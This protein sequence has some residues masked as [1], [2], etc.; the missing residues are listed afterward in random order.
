VLATAKILLRVFSCVPGGLLLLPLG[1]LLWKSFQ[2]SSELLI[3]V[4]KYLLWE[5]LRNTI[6]LLISVLLLSSIW[7]TLLAWIISRFQFVG[8]SFFRWALLLPLALPA[9]VVSFVWLANF[10]QSMPLMQLSLIL[11]FCLFPYIYLIVLESFERIDQNHLEV[12]SSL[13]VTRADVIRRIYRPMLL[14][15]LMAGISLVGM[16][17]L[18][19]FGSV[20][21][22]NFSV[23]TTL[24]YRSWFSLQSLETAAF[25]AMLH[26]LLLL[27]FVF[28][29]SLTSKGRLVDKNSGA[30]RRALLKKCSTFQSWGMG[31]IVMLIW[32]IAFL[33]PLFQ[34]VQWGVKDLGAFVDA[35]LLER[36]SN[37]LI[38][39]AAAALVT[40]I[41]AMI[42]TLAQ[43]YSKTSF[44][45]YVS[46][47]SV[48]GYGIPGTVIAV[49]WMVS[50]AVAF[51]SF[52]HL[53]YVALLALTLG[54][55]TRFLSLAQR[56]L[57]TSSERISWTIEESARS[58]GAST[59]RVLLKIHKP[60]LARAA[61]IGFLFVFI[62]TLKEM[63]MTL[64]M[65][66]YGWDTLSVR[67]YQFTSDGM[68]EEAA[69]PSLV[70]VAVSLVPLWFLR[71]R[72]Q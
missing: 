57:M 3:H 10:G 72:M 4:E 54:L 40:L 53:P 41:F 67:V 29:T 69:A 6:L 38:I 24:V 32:S 9:Y 27:V 22:F 61:G 26:I 70:L 14:P 11:S 49:G 25:L 30:P 19:D 15:A 55:A 64:L 66:P 52:H 8:R 63:P 12:A 2:I 18:A 35:R 56:P 28:M 37:S 36:I 31:F 1:F 59:G 13:G 50:L 7:G 5:S 42:L 45:N 48:I 44:Q 47:L 51:G 68:W 46:R 58:L 34:L 17:T 60:L 33:F 20:S 16:E 62:D 39:A 43:R 71:K 23:F 21:V 65:R